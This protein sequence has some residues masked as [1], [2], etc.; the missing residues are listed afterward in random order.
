V[1]LPICNE[2]IFII[3]DN[4]I[5]HLPNWQATFPIVDYERI[6]PNPSRSVKETFCYDVKIALFGGVPEL[7]SLFVTM[8]GSGGGKLGMK[9][10][11]AKKADRRLQLF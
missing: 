11:W 8:E 2:H 3:G 4:N 6:S 1:A 7:E 10:G 5:H 9:I